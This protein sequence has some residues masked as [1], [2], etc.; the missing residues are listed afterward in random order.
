MKSKVTGSGASWV[1][2]KEDTART[3]LR[4]FRRNQTDSSSVCILLRERENS[5]CKCS[6]W[7]MVGNVGH[8]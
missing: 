1:C 2:D 3:V 4:Q 6:N 7:G 5:Q 8:Q